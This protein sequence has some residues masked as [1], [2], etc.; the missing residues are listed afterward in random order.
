[1]IPLKKINPLNLS[2]KIAL[3]F[4]CISFTKMIGQTITPQ[5]INSAGS[6]RQLGSTGISIT[7]NVGEPFTQ[8]IGANFLI[9]QGFLQPDIV[10]IVGPTLSVIKSDVTCTG[11]NNGFISA[12]ISN[13]LP[14][15]TI[16]YNWLPI[17]LCPASDCSMVDSL[18][19]GT[20]TLQVIVDTGTKTD[21]LPVQIITINDINGPCKINIFNALTPNGDGTNDVFTIEN[22]NEF[23]KNT[24]TI[25][26][27]WGQQ[28]AEIKNYDN[29]TKY[30]P[31]REDAAKLVSTTYFYIINLGDGSNLIKGWVE[32]LKD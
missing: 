15:Y 10:S 12:A 20:Y 31:A 21:T 26:N 6:H 4:L 17:S 8:T 1:M 3:L 27:R 2:I 9:T 5:V 22:I 30:W 13:V 18:M 16:T 19:A 11:K 24:V 14:T 25:Y 28:I 7:D 29:V 23:P 32:I